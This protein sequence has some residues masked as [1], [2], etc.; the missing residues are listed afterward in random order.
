MALSVT[1]RGLIVGSSNLIE[2]C[3]RPEGC[4]LTVTVLGSQA[5]GICLDHRIGKGFGLFVTLYAKSTDK[6]PRQ[7]TSNPKIPKVSKAIA[8]SFY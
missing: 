3:Q 8:S 1:G 7:H 4:N 6:M 5:S 2:I